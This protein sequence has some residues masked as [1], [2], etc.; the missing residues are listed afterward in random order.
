M[1]QL[2]YSIKTNIYDFFYA[3]DLFTVQAKLSKKE[4]ADVQKYSLTM[5]SNQGLEIYSHIKPPMLTLESYLYMRDFSRHFILNFNEK[6]YSKDADIENNPITTI[7][8]LMRNDILSE[9]LAISVK[10]EGN[11]QIR[12]MALIR[13]TLELQKRYTLIRNNNG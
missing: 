4:R 8:Q 11:I 12:D 6:N 3:N 10:I 13:K 5:A 1:S 2:S 9:R 7:V